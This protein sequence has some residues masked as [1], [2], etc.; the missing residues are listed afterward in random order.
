[1]IRKNRM[2][3]K[4]KV[5]QTNWFMPKSNYSSITRNRQISDLLGDMEG[6]GLQ[7]NVML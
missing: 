4:E 5:D 6:V 1:M 3:S 7:V 2:R